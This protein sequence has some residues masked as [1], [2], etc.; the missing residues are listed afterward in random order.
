MQKKYAVR[1]FVWCA[2]SVIT[3]A[4]CGAEGNTATQTSQAATTAAQAA[5][6]TPEQPA[7]ATA[8]PAT[9]T[10][11]QPTAT[12]AQLTPAAAQPAAAPTVHSAS[13]TATPP[14]GSSV[15]GPITRIL[16]I[17]GTPPTTVQ[18]GQTYTFTPLVAAPSGEAL[19][20]FIANRPVW[21]TFS[22]ATGQ[23]S[24]APTSANQGTFAHIVISVEG[25]GTIA[26]LRVFSIQV[27]VAANSAPTT[28]PTPNSAAAA[29]A[30]ANNNPLCGAPIM[31]FYWE[32]G[33][34]S[35]A[36]ISGSQG[37]DPNG[38]A[39]LATTQ[40]SIASASKWIYATYVTQLRG[41]ADQLSAQDINFLHFTSGYSNMDNPGTA[42]P[43]TDNPDSVNQ[44]L[45]LTNAKG[46][47]FSAQ[48]P[49][50]VGTFDYNGGHME[51]HASQLTSLGN[52]AV[53]SVGPTMQALLGAGV[54]LEYTE[55]LMSGGILTSAQNYTLVLR[56]VLDGTLVMHDALGTNQVCTH[57]SATC[58]ATFSPI[59]EAWHYSIGHW[60]E[61]DPSTNGDGAFS[62]PGAFGFYPWIDSTKSYYGVISRDQSTGSGEQQGYASAQCGR[63][64]RHAWMTGIEQTQSLP[65]N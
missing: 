61:N 6:T 22:T 20:F 2:A 56:H 53:G 48:D 51:N 32:I 19:R 62:S 59:K 54:T 1:Y 9:V 64:I 23:L 18:A 34:Q 36:L 45:K 25:G 58:K 52:I 35:G 17:A 40:L 33:D 21:A 39:V 41:A 57:P 50:T 44:C 55:P 15:K 46:V 29:T 7:T 30:T 42:C 26:S 49:A 38:N 14:A 3:L 4:G 43:H 10:A 63:L 31:P 5:A 37:S 60:V 27:Q 16:V 47:S 12:A 11:A 65:M 28:A 8:A 13:S 24:G